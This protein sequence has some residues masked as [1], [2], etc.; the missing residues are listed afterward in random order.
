MFF[1][2]F[3]HDLLLVSPLEKLL[4]HLL[5]LIN[6]GCRTD[7]ANYADVCFAA[8]GD[9][10]KYWITFDEANDWAGLGYSTNQNPPGRCTPNIIGQTNLNYG[11]CPEGDSGTE[12]YI[13]G[14]HLLL[15][16]AEAVSIYRTKYQVM[17]H[18]L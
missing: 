10:I 4:M 6:H 14:H 13:V 9:R 3:P 1:S 18:F 2:L 11:N 12:P 8:F 16:H 7:F 15:A 17:L 5:N